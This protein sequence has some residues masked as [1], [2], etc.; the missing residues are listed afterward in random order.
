MKKIKINWTKAGAGFIAGIMV[1]SIIGFVGGSF[2]SQKEEKREYKGFIFLKKENV[3]T[4][5]LKETNYD[6]QFL[7]S[8]LEDISFSSEFSLET[9]S[10]YLGYW[11]GETINFKAAFNLLGSVFY[12]HYGILSQ[13]A[14]LKEEDCPGLPLLDCQKEKG[15]VI[16]SGKENN[17]TQE[18]NCLIIKASNN[19]EL[20]KLTERFAYYLLG[21]MD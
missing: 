7:P 4:L 10:L 6:F 2:F 9:S 19:Q 18:D 13:K 14:C 20:R 8:E 15:I 21:V 11:P 17:Y 16:T 12:N 5:K 1:L 3:W